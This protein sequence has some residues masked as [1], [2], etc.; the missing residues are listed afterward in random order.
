[1]KVARLSALRNGRLYPQANIPK[2]R[3]K[4]V[5]KPVVTQQQNKIQGFFIK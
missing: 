2:I 3:K 1:M 4:V 5:E